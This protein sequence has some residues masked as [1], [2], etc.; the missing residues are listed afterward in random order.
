VKVPCAEGGAYCGEVRAISTF[1][2]VGPSQPVFIARG[3]SRDNRMRFSLKGGFPFSGLQSWLWG[4]PSP[5]SGYQNGPL[6]IPCSVGNCSNFTKKKRLN[7]PGRFIGPMRT[8]KL[9]LRG[10]LRPQRPGSLTPTAISN[11]SGP[12]GGA[13]IAEKSTLRGGNLS[14]AIEK[15]TPY[16]TMEILKPRR[17]PPGFRG[18]PGLLYAGWAMQG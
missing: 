4:L 6:M 2:S 9:F 7:C 18:A 14:A 13:G 5:E 11:I 1:R 17:I 16:K 15:G 10:G 12:F 8:A 3:K